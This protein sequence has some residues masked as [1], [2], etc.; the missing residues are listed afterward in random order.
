MFSFHAK[1]TFELFPGRCISVFRFLINSRVS[2][3]DRFSGCPQVLILTRRFS[4]DRFLLETQIQNP[5]RIK[6]SESL[7]LTPPIAKVTRGCLSSFR[8]APKVPPLSWLSFGL[9]LYGTVFFKFSTVLAR[10][11]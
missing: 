5:S 9:S 4:R 2:I 11:T 6:G 7:I 8:P 1:A 10:E 3:L